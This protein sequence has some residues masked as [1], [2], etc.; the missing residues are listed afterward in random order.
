MAHYI[1]QDSNVPE[2]Y[3]GIG[4]RI[5]DDLVI[6][7]T[8][9]DILIPDVPKDIDEIE[10]LWLKAEPSCQNLLGYQGLKNCDKCEIRNFSSSYRFKLPV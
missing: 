5:E 10:R 4:V 1:S 9:V 8:G 7:A 2:K 6:T 3:K